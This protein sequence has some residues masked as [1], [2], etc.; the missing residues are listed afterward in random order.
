VDTGAAHIG[1]LGEKPL[2]ASLKRWCSETGDRFEVPTDGYVIDI[3]RDGLLIEVQTRGF[4]AM[5]R[6]IPALLELG[7]DVR[8]V[9]PIPANKWIVKI[10]PYGTILSRRLS[11]KHGSAVD[12]FSELV[13]FPELVD[14]PQLEVV[15]VIIDEE[16]YRFHTPDKSWRR[17]G[18]SVKERRLV[19]VLD[20]L[21]ITSS[22]DL[23]AL[24]PSG[25]PNP[26]TTADLATAL[27]RPRR[28]AQQMAYCLRVS[29]VIEA[30][31]K[32]GNA[33]E[34][35]LTAPPNP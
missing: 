4:T 16:E 11:P 3:V 27:A 12:V 10:D 14:H 29:G 22:D 18:W 26:F 34:Y 6:K 32:R 28:L 17:K 2:H 24:L 7:H 5:K 13:S 19:D 1:T 35:A 15:L 9:H 20:S 31:G 8:I 33:V 21:R 30:S 25:L 23:L